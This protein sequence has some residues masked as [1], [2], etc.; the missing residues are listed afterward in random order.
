MVT[1]GLIK[2]HQ[3]CLHRRLIPVGLSEESHGRMNANKHLG[4]IMVGTLHPQLREDVILRPYSLQRGMAVSRRGILRGRLIDPCFQIRGRARH[5][6]SKLY[7]GS[8]FLRPGRP[9]MR[10]QNAR[11]EQVGRVLGIGLGFVHAGARR[12]QP[13][14][15][16]YRRCAFFVGLLSA[17]FFS[18]VRSS[19]YCLPERVRSVTAAL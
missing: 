18:S 2:V 11:G 9:R 13:D 4:R 15:V 3:R 19:R 6:V 1:S 10:R 7:R 8:K 16:G 5:A 17:S 14:E 12:N